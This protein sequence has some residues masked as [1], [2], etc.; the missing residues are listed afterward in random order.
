MKVV[1]IVGMAGSG[2]SEAARL[3]ERNGFFR[4]RFGDIT[5]RE[6]RRQG[7]EINEENERRVRERLRHEHGM[8]AYALLNMPFIDEALKRSNVVADG[9]YSWEEYCL[10][11]ERYDPDFL[12]VAVCASP[13]TRYARLSSRADRK[14]TPEE[15]ASRDRAEIEN[16]NKGGP[17]A[18]ADFCITNEGPVD[19][20]FREVTK[21][22]ARINERVYQA[23]PG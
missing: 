18:M 5:E 4:V 1:A 2:K 16:V 19:D 22:I 17:I 12:V 21:I 3:F 9:L 8:A 15:A 14:L 20:F 10:F 11:K 13:A 7:L 23:R 6:L